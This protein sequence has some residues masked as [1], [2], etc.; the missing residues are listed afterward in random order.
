[1]NREKSINSVSL[2]CIAL[3]ERFLDYVLV[4]PHLLLTMILQCA[5]AQIQYPTRPALS[6]SPLYVT[7][8]NMLNPLL[9]FSS[10]S[11]HLPAGAPLSETPE[12][13]EVICAIELEFGIKPV[14]VMFRSSRMIVGLSQKFP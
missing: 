3:F 14:K 8:V 12:G 10:Y 2:Y 13:I 9:A 5:Q 11:F 7:F 1:M 6:L 4:A